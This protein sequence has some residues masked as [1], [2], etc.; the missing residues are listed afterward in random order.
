M[1]VLWF[2]GMLLARPT[3]LTLLL[4]DTWTAVLLTQGQ[5]LGWGPEDALDDQ[6]VFNRLARMGGTFALVGDN[7]PGAKGAHSRLFWAFE[8]RLKLG[9][10]SPAYFVNG[11]VYFVQRLSQVLHKKPVVVHN[12]F[13]FFGT[14]GKVWR[15]R[16]A[17]LWAV[18]SAAWYTKGN[19]LSF[20]TAL[21]EEVLNGIENA[22]DRHVAAVS[23][24]YLSIRNALAIA[25]I[26]NRTLIL[27]PFTCYCDK[28]WWSLTEPCRM[29]GVDEDPPYSPCPLDHVLNL[30]AWSSSRFAIREHSFLEN[31][32]VPA[33]FKKARKSIA[34]VPRP[35]RGTA[36][37]QSL[38]K[39]SIPANAL[40]FEIQRLLGRLSR[41]RVL[42]L[43]TS[44]D[45]FCRFK[46]LE[47]N[48][49]FDSRTL[50]AGLFE[51]EWCC[52]P[53]Q[54]EWGEETKDSLRYR[55]FKAPRPLAD[56]KL[57]DCQKEPTIALELD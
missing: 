24:Y 27:P 7:T 13:Q 15:F 35:A 57:A 12:T 20:D 46:A 5:V 36:S 39:D 17:Q 30:P 23:F 8:K 54:D 37:L 16:E 2:S 38:A 44:A 1:L 3:N 19:F 55:R 53:W 10:L 43:E 52:L 22:V 47:R 33:F 29:P 34:V 42:H 56:V 6:D 40:D 31:P 28:Y 4:M 21:P 51:E 11:H 18:D 45:A 49:D 14:Q 32:Q 48:V 25:H 50:G 41:T 26:L 9:V